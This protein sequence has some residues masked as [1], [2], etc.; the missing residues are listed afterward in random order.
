MRGVGNLI[1]QKQRDE[2]VADKST[3][4]NRREYPSLAK[5]TNTT[6]AAS[7]GNAMRNV[8]EAAG[9]RRVMSA[10]DR[11]ASGRRARISW[12]RLR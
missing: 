9:M 3:V 6:M 2:I 4:L 5:G 10:A 7:T 11:F 12:G 1:K 8:S